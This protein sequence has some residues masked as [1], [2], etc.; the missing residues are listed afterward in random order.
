MSKLTPQ[1]TR[2]IYQKLPEDLKDAILSVDS[3]NVIQQVGKKYNLMI[4]KIGELADE[5]GMVMFG[6]TPPKDFIS[7]LSRRLGGD[8]ETARKIAED[9]NKQI[10][11]K[12]RESLK[13]IHNITGTSEQNDFAAGQVETGNYEL[14]GAKTEI[15]KDML[16]EIESEEINK[17]EK[18]NVP[19]ILKGLNIPEPEKGPFEAKTSEEIHRKP[20]QVSE[21]YLE[22]DPYQEPIK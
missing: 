1:Q 14:G 7:N 10:F 3:A 13:K 5:T 21:H 2:E 22:G 6:V 18:S 11:A 12:V 15:K 4:D 17:D 19:E 9:I 16:K 8:R 20:L